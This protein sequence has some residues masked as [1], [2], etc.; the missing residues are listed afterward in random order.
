MEQKELPLEIPGGDAGA[1]PRIAE[2]VRMLELFASVGADCFDIIHTNEAQEKRG[3]R[4]GQN[5]GQARESMRFLVPNARM[6]KN[7]LIIR[8]RSS[9]TPPTTTP[10]CLPKGFALCW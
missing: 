4:P 10:P 8:P 7:N 3:F 5:L 6:R 1:A 2:A 9:T